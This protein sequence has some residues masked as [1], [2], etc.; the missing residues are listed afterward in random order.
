MAELIRPEVLYLTPS[1]HSRT[2]IAMYGQSYLNVFSQSKGL[3]MTPMLSANVPENLDGVEDAV[4]E[5]KRMA[6]ETLKAAGS[7]PSQVLHVEL[8]LKTMREFWAAYHIAR[9]R[10]GHRYWWQ[11]YPE[12]VALPMC[13]VFHDPPHLPEALKQP[14]VNPKSHFLV[15]W[16]TRVS[17]R[18]AAR[19]QLRMSQDFLERA[20]AFLALSRRSAE[21]LAQ[22]YPMM[23]HKIGYLPPMPIGPIPDRIEPNERGKSD[24]VRILS[25]G[26][27]RQDKGIE[28]ILDAMAILNHRMPLAGKADLMI[29]GR[30][31]R[32]AVETN[33]SSTLKQYIEKRQL[34]RLVSFIPG[35]LKEQSVHELLREADILVLPY[36]PGA[37]ESVSMTMLRAETWCLAI[38]ASDTGSMKEYINH[39]SDGLLFPVNNPNALA[40]CLERLIKNQDMRNDMALARRRRALNQRSS[41][42]VSALMLALYREM[43][44]SRD[45]ERPFVMP[46]LMR[47]PGVTP[48]PEPE[49]AAEAGPEAAPEQANG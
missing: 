19:A 36:R 25:F 43:L 12:G 7:I 29:R 34:R 20:C 40:D 27:I 38:V 3:T 16:M 35:A 13:V 17:N 8:G 9:K 33:Y 22:R 1:S 46:E 26:F 45:E 28:T 48:E 44:M 24:A 4:S 14:E 21:L 37:C 5:V 10:S 42:Q 15:R 31:T 49:P 47:V 41:A 6:A 18:L 32:E 30:L 23:R 11:K 2:P 39:G